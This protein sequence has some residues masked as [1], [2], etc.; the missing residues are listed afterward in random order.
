MTQTKAD[1]SA[2]AKKGAATRQRNAQRTRS[3]TAGTKAAATRQGRTAA[4][5][6]NE[7]TTAVKSA[8]RGLTGAAKAAGDAAKNAGKAAA[9]R[10]GA[11]RVGRS[12]HED[13]EED[14]SSLSDVRTSLQ[15]RNP[16]HWRHDKN[17]QRP[18]SSS[19]KPKGPL[20]R[21]GP[22]GCA[23]RSARVVAGH[24]MSE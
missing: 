23:A 18:S 14:A 3:Q 7:A 6:A 16:V 1:R 9:T 15:R 24:T 22:F 4:S 8:A 12:K 20:H 10:A 19:L 13:H 5:S 21:A 17:S 11:A 2:A